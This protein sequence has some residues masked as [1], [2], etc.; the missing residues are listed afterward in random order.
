MGIF[1]QPLVFSFL[2]RPRG[3]LTVFPSKVMGNCG[4]KK[5][6]EAA[7]IVEPAIASTL[8]EESSVGVKSQPVS[9]Q[10]EMPADV[11]AEILEAVEKAETAVAEVAAEMKDEI[12]AVE[13]VVVR[14]AKGFCC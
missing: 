13:E 12:V 11:Q 6:V 3:S 7:G 10:T 2:L 1:V 14:K 5:G 4:T 8:V 9:E